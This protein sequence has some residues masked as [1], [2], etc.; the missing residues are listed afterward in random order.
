MKIPTFSLRLKG[1]RQ[2]ATSGAPGYVLGP[3]HGEFTSPQ[4]L[5]IGIAFTTLA[6]VFLVGGYFYAL[7]TP[8]MLTQFLI[9]LLPLAGVAIWALPDGH[10]AYRKAISNLF[11][12]FLFAV[13]LW[14][15]YLAIALPGLPW[16]TSVRLLGFPLCYFL[17]VSVST[18]PDFR[19]EIAETARAAAPSC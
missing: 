10:P 4:K 17:L 2:S 16:I 12:A 11:F 15:E 7:T 9:P 6:L 18:S 5:L 19:S 13:L 8:F 1:G 3:Y 14:P